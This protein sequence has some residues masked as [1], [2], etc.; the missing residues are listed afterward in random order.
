[1]DLAFLSAVFIPLGIYAM[2]VP[3]PGPGFIVIVRASITEG[4]AHGSAAALGTTVSVSVYAFA[5]TLGI[6]TVLA[7]LPWLSS[8]IQIAGGAYLV[9]MGFALLRSSFAPRNQLDSVTNTLRESRESPRMCFR[10]GL[11]VGLSNPKMAAFFLGLLGPAMALDLSLT[12]Q[13]VVLGGVILI[14][15]AYHQSLAWVMAKGRGMVRDSGRWFEFTVGG[16]L[17][18]FGGF[19]IT[20]SIGQS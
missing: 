1:M 10:R 16:S 17:I 8:T 15:F 12:A 3:F 14:D 4:P 13:L 2:A 20:R 9:W 18:A 6:S 19:M 11:L 5:T 7:A